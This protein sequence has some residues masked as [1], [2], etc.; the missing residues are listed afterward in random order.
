MVAKIVLRFSLTIC[1]SARRRARVDLPFTRRF[2]FA[3]ARVLLLVRP[4]L[5]SV[6]AILFPYSIKVAMAI[7]MQLPM[8]IA[9]GISLS[10]QFGI[11]IHRQP[12]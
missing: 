8:A 4:L 1:L 10:I 6:A 5:R 2:A 3:S 7:K 11:E 12:R 9:T